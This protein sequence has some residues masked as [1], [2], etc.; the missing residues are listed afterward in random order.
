LPNWYLDLANERNI[1]DSR[2]VTFAELKQFR[3]AV[4]QLDPARLVT[5]SHAGDISRDD[6]R[7]YLLTVRVDFIAPHRGRVV[8]ARR[9]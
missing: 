8:S 6:L 3:D 4:K 7:E 2:F 9:S 5:A 1:G